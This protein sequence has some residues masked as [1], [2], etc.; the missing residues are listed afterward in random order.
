[1]DIFD[2]V[3]RTIIDN[4]IGCDAT[5]AYVFSKAKGGKSG[6]SFGICQFDIN[7]NPSSLLCLRECEF[8]TDEVWELKN[9]FPLELEPFN[10]K[11]KLHHDI[12]DRWD[13]Q[14]IRDCITR[15]ENN[16]TR[17]GF[18]PADMTAKV[19]MCDYN[20]QYNFSVGGKLYAFCQT[21]K[22]PV[23]AGDIYGF[24]K[25]T[26]WGQEDP[27]DVKHRYN[28]VLKVMQGDASC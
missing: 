14:Q 2:A 8:T 13:G 27:E 24:K 5:L 19:M 9:T 10:E 20:N 16:C 21:L 15:V 28:T 11:L 6:R 18:I 23:T 25:L 17:G 26:K 12:V 7:N 3:R 1:M 22:R 4:E